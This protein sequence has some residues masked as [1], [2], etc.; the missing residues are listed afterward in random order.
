MTISHEQSK[1]FYEDFSVAVGLRDWLSPNLRHVKLKLL[2]RQVVAGRG[3]N[4]RVADVGCGAG[5]MTDY[6][7]KFGNVVGVDF[8][9]AAVAAAQKRSKATF[10]VGGPDALP[11]G[12]YDLVTLFDVLEHIPLDE[13]ASFIARLAQCLAPNGILFCSTPYPT[14]TRRRKELNDPTLQIIDE[15]VR[16]PAVVSEAGAAGLQ[17]LGFFTYDVFSGSPE[18]QAFVFSLER[19]PG[20]EASLISLDFRLAKRATTIRGMAR[21]RRIRL[22]VRAVCRR[23]F[24][25]AYWFLTAPVPRVGS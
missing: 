14:A 9:S 23:E 24:K 17:L 6:L 18:Y 1:A 15:E 5:V 12:T 4:L 3:T 21:L 11:T 7:R 13:R 10:A 20:V 22:A 8:S 25:T 19:T 2:I 16:L